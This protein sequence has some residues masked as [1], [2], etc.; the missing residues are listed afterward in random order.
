[1]QSVPV[2]L[3]TFEFCFLE[4]DYTLVRVE[5]SDGEVTIRAT[6]D[7]FSPRRKLNFIRE[8]GAEGFI[9]DDDRWTLR[10]DAGSPFRGVRWL[11]D[12]SW[13]QVDEALNARNQR[14]VRRF[15][16]PVTLLW[17]LMLSLVVPAQGKPGA[18]R[19][20]H[21]PAS[22]LQVSEGQIQKVP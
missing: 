2:K 1:M 21:P 20:K 17:L 12:S 16:L 10:D 15:I 11:V 14:L 13:L 3:R 18:T 8:L 7:T 4:L 9:P 19:S 6:A 5:E 22:A